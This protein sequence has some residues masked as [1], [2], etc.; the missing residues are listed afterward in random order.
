MDVVEKEGAAGDAA[1][2]VVLDGFTRFHPAAGSLEFDLVDCL[3]SPDLTAAEKLEAV[4]RYS[5]AVKGL[6]VDEVGCE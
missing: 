4:E 6:E 5:E 2:G 3:V 1:C